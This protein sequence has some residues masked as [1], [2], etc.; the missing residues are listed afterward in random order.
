MQQT[1]HKQA[2]QMRVMITT[3]NAL[4]MEGTFRSNNHNAEHDTQEQLHV[5]ACAI[6]M[7]SV[8]L[9]PVPTHTQAW[10]QE[11]RQMRPQTE[12]ALKYLQRL[13]ADV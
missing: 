10:S 5:L 8:Q 2:I 7:R 6:A 1:R 3:P 4:G 13:I 12:V 11:Q 9:L